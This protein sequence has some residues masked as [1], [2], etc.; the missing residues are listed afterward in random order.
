MAVR[1]PLGQPG[2]YT[3]AVQRKIGAAGTLH[4]AQVDCKSPRPKIEYRGIEEAIHLLALIN[5]L[6]GE[7]GLSRALA[8]PSLLPPGSFYLCAVVLFVW[9][10]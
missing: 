7:S 8:L 2:R 3:P 5:C 4:T 1:H 9:I 6:L 10:R